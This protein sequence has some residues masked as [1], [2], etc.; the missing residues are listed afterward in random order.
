MSRI[1]DVDFANNFLTQE[2]E[3]ESRLRQLLLSSPADFEIWLELIKQI[4]KYVKNI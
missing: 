2:R 1:L 4:E 3:E